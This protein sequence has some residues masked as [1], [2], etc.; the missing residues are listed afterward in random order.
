MTTIPRVFVRP[1]AARP[2]FARHPWVFATSIEKLEG[3]PPP[4]GEVDVMTHDGVF[5]AR[6]LYNPSSGIRVRLYRWEREPIDE[7]FLRERL[8]IAVDLRVR[9]LGLGGRGRAT[10]LVFSEGDGLSGLTVDRFDRGLV[11]Q[12]SGLGLYL[13]K[14]TILDALLAI[15]PDVDSITIKGDRS[16]AE[17]EGLTVEEGLARGRVSEGETIIEENGVR[18]SLD[19]GGGQ[20]TGFYIDQRENRRVV[21]GFARNRDVLD[22]YCYSGGFGLNAAMHGGAKS[23]L[24]VDSSGPAIE[25]AR[26]NAKINGVEIAEYVEDDVS[27]RIRILAETGRTFGLVVCDPPKFVRHPKHLEKGL[28]TYLRLNRSAIDL[29]EPGGIL[30]T[31]SCSGAVDRELFAQVLA[32]ASELARRPIRILEIRGQAAD[33]PVSAAC[34]ES[35]YL[36]CVICAVE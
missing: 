14:E 7:A 31:C 2:F 9:V 16:T 5:I 8:R 27:G 13:R 35:E 1:R 12:F 4:G 18:Y 36:E 33:H 21:A 32:Q 28:K 34:L 23:I 24:G 10:R 26:R 11:A 19:L 25:L 22:L 3:D 30:A 20:K 6:G 29:V 17:A 15:V